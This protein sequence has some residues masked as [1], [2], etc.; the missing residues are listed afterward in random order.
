ME[1]IAKKLKEYGIPNIGNKI[2]DIK[3][4]NLDYSFAFVKGKKNL[5]VLGEDYY[6]KC[7]RLMRIR[8]L[9]NKTLMYKWV[10]QSQLSKP[11]DVEQVDVMALVQIF[12]E[13]SEYKRT[14][15]GYAVNKVLRGGGQILIGG[16]DIETLEKA[17]PYDLDMIEEEFLFWS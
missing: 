8:F 1:V 10:S 11:D 17:F 3:D 4:Y 14:L 9:R 7:A 15:T 13:P 5:V 16:N 6:K 12:E 2:S